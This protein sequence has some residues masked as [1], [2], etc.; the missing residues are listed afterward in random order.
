MKRLS[1][2]HYRIRLRN[3]K[4]AKYQELLNDSIIIYKLVRLPE[5]RIIYYA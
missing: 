3:I 1:P 2:Q 4:K 5:K